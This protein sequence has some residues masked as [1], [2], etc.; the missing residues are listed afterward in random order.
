VTATASVWCYATTAE[1]QWWSGMWADRV[2]E[3]ALAEQ[4][5]S[6]G[7]ATRADLKRMSEA[8]REWGQ[9]EDGW[10]AVLHGEILARG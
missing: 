3:S 10:F 7:Y 4:A 2:V 1:R 9:A 5:V 6:Y 8:W